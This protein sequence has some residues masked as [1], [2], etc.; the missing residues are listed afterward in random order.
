MKLKNY[1]N[2]LYRF[3]GARL[4]LL[5]VLMSL[6]GAT[7]GIGLALIIPFLN[8]IGIDA[9]TGD[10]A[11]TRLFVRSFIAM[12]LPLN[13]ATVTAAYTFIII[14][15]AAATR[16]KEV[17][18]IQLVTGFTHHLRTR[19]YAHFCY[20]DWQVFLNTRGSDIIHVL[21]QDVQ[22]MAFATQQVFQ[23][24]VSVVILAIYILFCMTMSFPMT[25][26]AFLC[27][28]LFLLLLKPF[29]RKVVLFG[30]IFRDSANRMHS[31]IDNHIG[32]MKVSKSY[33]LESYH[34]KEFEVASKKIEQQA[35][36]FT[37]INSATRFWYQAGTAIAIAVFI[38]M[39]I[40][41]FEVPAVHL[42]VM[43]FLFSR[44]LPGLSRAQQCFQR[45]I[46]AM[47]SFEGVLEMEKKL[48]ENQE[49]AGVAP[50][51]PDAAFTLD[52]AIDLD[53]LW[54][55]YDTGSDW[56]L[57]QA[58]QT[59]P[60]RQITA[61]SG[62]SGTGKTTMADLILGLLAPARGSIFIDGTLLDKENRRAWRKCVGYVP[63]DSYLFH[64]SIRD[65]LKKA[66]PDADDAQLWLAL[67]NA[68]AKEFVQGLP[69]QLDTIVGDRGMRLSGGERQ[70][71]A[72]A[73][74]LLSNPL[75]LVL[76]EATS[77]LDQ[78]NEQ[79]ILS[80][81]VKLKGRLTII[82]IAHNSFPR[83]IADHTILME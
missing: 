18:S 24:I 48:K 50:D 34:E 6:L 35:E 38:A 29:N 61:V 27:G 44:I 47:P 28:G 73:M 51:F 8:A 56:A 40:R 70:R 39:G 42:M 64:E 15:Y 4:W 23:L 81:L 11:Y 43:V 19:V 26:A 10:S 45:I 57:K 46:N 53:N 17:L 67:E 60:A 62:A 12:G 14:V 69:A 74:A 16:Y 7:Q 71:I 49:T 33:G 83:K 63:Q 21:T 82:I 41:V 1:L 25:S 80:A 72:M 13:L 55:R 54:F 5:L 77:A 75:L 20:S 59:I 32:G 52:S 76:D 9:G 58:R 36:A 31:L 2:A 78:E 37:R 65:N 66:A 30:G 3:A 22:R 68:A 79:K